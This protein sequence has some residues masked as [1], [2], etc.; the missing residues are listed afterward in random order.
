MV[1]LIHGMTLKSLAENC[2]LFPV[3]KGA[4][5][6]DS[7][8]MVHQCRQH[9]PI[10]CWILEKQKNISKS[11]THN[12]KTF[13]SARGNYFL[14]TVVNAKQQRLAKHGKIGLQTPLFH[15]MHKSPAK[16]IQNENMFVC[17]LAVC[18]YL[19]QPKLQLHCNKRS[20]WLDSYPI[21]GI[22]V[23]TYNFPDLH[24]PKHVML[25]FQTCDLSF[26]SVFK[27]HLLT[28]GEKHVFCCL[29]P[30]WL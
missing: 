8:A 26:N 6:Y 24:F 18:M 7:I 9:R 3:Q 5:M 1:H 2:C 22:D 21:Q 12:D 25:L 23:N 15:R 13:L 30:P 28:L 20:R 10:I 11:K 29:S 17:C 16:K 19:T 27:L 14:N 4:L